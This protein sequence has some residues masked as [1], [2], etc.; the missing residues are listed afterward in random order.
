MSLCFGRS[1]T[2]ND[3]VQTENKVKNIS[4]DYRQI[5]CSSL[6]LD[7]NT[8]KVSKGPLLKL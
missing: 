1:Q 5:P 7:N 6:D 8:C 3:Y 4:E 2:K